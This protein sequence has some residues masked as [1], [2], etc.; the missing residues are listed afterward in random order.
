MSTLFDLPRVLQVTLALAAV[1]LPLVFLYPVECGE[2]TTISKPGIPKFG[3]PPTSRRV[4]GTCKSALRLPYSVK[5]RGEMQAAAIGFS[6]AA[7]V[8]SIAVAG[9]GRDRWLSGRVG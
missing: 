7:L 5:H 8:G 9:L 6:L 1:V 3:I 2:G 4:P